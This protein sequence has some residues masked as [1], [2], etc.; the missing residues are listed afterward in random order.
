MTWRIAPLASGH[1]R[2]SFSCANAA[3]DEYFHKH[4]TQDVR[5]RVASCFVVIGRE[6]DIAGFY[7]LASASLPVNDLPPDMARK[8][9]RYPVIPSI[10]VGRL[11]VDRKYQRQGIG[12]ILLIDSMRRALRA[13]A[14][15]FALLVDAR[16]DNAV[17]FYR[18]HGFVSFDSTPKT[19]FLPLATAEKITIAKPGIT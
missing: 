8:L 13:E 5:R 1:D 19:L 9:P 4:V 10:R 7:T 12:S 6:N 14:G 2:A 3:L 11:A 18:H 16:D 17:S 15:T